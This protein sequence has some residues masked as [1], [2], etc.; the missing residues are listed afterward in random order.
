M[1]AHHLRLRFE[2]NCFEPQGFEP[3]GFEPQG[4][5]PN[6]KAR[7][8]MLFPRDVRTNRPE[9]ETMPAVVFQRFDIPI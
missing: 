4:F 2:S 9:R 8:Q 5:E 1:R 7:R 3:Q 6:T